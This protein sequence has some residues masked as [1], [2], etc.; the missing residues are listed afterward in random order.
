MNVCSARWSVEHGVVLLSLRL[1]HAYDR[2]L[3]LSFL[4]K[5][6]NSYTYCIV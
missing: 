1:A 5:I 2:R 3:S 4:S 6:R